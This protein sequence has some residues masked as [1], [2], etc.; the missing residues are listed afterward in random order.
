M[1]YNRYHDLYTV[2]TQ[3]LRTFSANLG[4]DE[5]GTIA[6]FDR[7]LFSVAREVPFL[8]HLDGSEEP[9]VI[10]RAV[11]RFEKC[12][13]LFELALRLVT[14]GTSEADAKRLLSMKRNI[15]R[16]HGTRSGLPS[17]EVRLREWANR[18]TQ[19]QV[20]LGAMGGGDEL[21]DSDAD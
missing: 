1:I 6:L 5:S 9:N 15:A 16:L 13:A 7:R 20:S 12:S 17:M 21:D 18:P 8:Q 4:L 14:C 2:S 19:V 3:Y 10:W 11:H